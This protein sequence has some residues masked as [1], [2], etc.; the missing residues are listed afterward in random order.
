MQ[1]RILIV[2]DNATNL[3]LAAAT[4]RYEGHEVITAVDAESA[5]SLI[6]V[7]P[8]F[9][10]ILM[11]VSLPGMDGLTLTKLLKADPRTA[12]VPIVILT[13]SA[14]RGDEL[15]ARTAGADGFIAKP[16]SVGTFPQ[17]IAE[18]LRQRG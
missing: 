16:I 1:A 18:H 3:K 17:L 4:L 10:L 15:N 7:S 5:H 2:D 14:M 13:A 8:E 12:H 6:S 9:D 11:D